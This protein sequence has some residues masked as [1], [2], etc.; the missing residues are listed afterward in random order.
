M[1][2]HIVGPVRIKKRKQRNEMKTDTAQVGCSFLASHWFSFLSFF[3]LGNVCD[4]LSEYT[5]LNLRRK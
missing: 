1:S 3:D 5:A 4:L 2:S